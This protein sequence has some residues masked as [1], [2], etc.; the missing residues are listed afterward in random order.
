MRTSDYT[1]AM[2]N[3]LQR[4]LELLSEESVEQLVERIARAQKVFVAGAGRSGL[5]MR[6]FAMR[7]MHMGFAVYVVG[8]TVTPGLGPDDLLI[9]G[10]GSGET[11]SLAVM[12]AKAK[13]IGASLAAATTNPESTIGQISDV[14]I[15]VLASPKEASDQ[16]S[17]TIQPMGSLF[18]QSLLLVFD[19]II[20]RMMDRQELDGSAMF[21]RHA[22][23]E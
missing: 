7:L 20:L 10:S 15:Q 22:N 13:G 5:M 12:A 14:V 11:K 8:E 19:S 6:A 23:L 18:E 9:I 2:I 17:F 4:T 3:E 21:G 16:E 1:S